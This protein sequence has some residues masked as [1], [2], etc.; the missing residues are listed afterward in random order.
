MDARKKMRWRRELTAALGRSCR[1][2]A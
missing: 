1:N 2:S